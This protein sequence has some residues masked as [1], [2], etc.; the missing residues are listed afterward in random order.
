MRRNV[1]KETA[2]A[3][4]SNDVNST[5]MRSHGG[6]YTKLKPRGRKPNYSVRSIDFDIFRQTRQYFLGAVSMKPIISAKMP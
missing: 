5:E 3:V 4:S 1:Y 2:V 6:N